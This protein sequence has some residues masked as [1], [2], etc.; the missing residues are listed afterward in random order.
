MSQREFKDRVSFFFFF[1]CF[2]NNIMNSQP[3][4]SLSP[5]PKIPDPIKE[6]PLEPVK[7]TIQINEHVLEREENKRV[8]NE[9]IKDCY[10]NP[11]QQM[12]QGSRQV[13]QSQMLELAKS[14]KEDDWVYEGG[15]VDTS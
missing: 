10:Q 15:S 8:L 9:I 3:D 5:L 13:L 6:P 2:I 14:L 11:I 1:F 4:L 12:E 7:N